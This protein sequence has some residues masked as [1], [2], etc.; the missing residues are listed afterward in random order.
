MK[1]RFALV[2][3]ALV[4]L[5]GCGSGSKTASIPSG[6]ET[7]QIKTLTTTTNVKP[8][9]PAGCTAVPKPKPRP[10]GS[11]EKPSTKLDASKSW[12]ATVKTNCG[13]FAFLLDVK[14][15]PHA[16]ASI[17][18]LAGRKFY[19]G[20]V[21]HRIVPG[22]VIQGGDPTG[23]GGGG[24]GYSTVDKP[25]AG[26]KYTKG[27]VAMAKTGSEPPG[28]AGSQFFV[29]TGKDAG[30]PPDYAVVGKVSQGLDVVARIGKLGD[31]AEEPTFDVVIQSLRV[32]SG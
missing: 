12:T 32:T 3:V 10:D 8:A 2:P 23:E 28:T 27:V 6:N 25:S 26:A 20:T 9:T 24:P 16:T 14:A 19:D 31:Q 1:L 13:T 22:F 21:F 17:A 7:A 5:A 15:A 18:Y 30:L 29:V 11:L 4:A